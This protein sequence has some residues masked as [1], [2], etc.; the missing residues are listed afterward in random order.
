MR[1][2]F[3]ASTH[4]YIL[5]FTSAGKV[6]WLKVHAIPEVGS[7]GKGRPIVNLIQIRP[8]EKVCA[9]IAVR[10][11][12]E[13][14]HVV[15]A[16]RCGYI[17]KTELTRVLAAPGRGHHRADDRERRTTCCPPACTSGQDEIF[18]ATA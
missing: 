10:E 1:H 6:H 14:R 17:K 11:F 12:S 3:V 16:T 7:A 13:G 4:D 18:M 2:L 5:V 8:G 15:L 9:T